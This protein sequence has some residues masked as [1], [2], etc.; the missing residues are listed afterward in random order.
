MLIALNRIEKEFQS[1]R[2]GAK[3]SV[4]NGINLTVEKGEL[5]AIRG[6]SGA[7]KSTLLHILGCLDRPTKGTYFLNGEDITNLPLNKLAW[8]RNQKIGF[9]LQH[10]SLVEEDTVLEN[11]GIPLL[12]GRVRMSL[13]D[14]MAMEQLHQLGIDHLANQR[15]GTLSGGEKQRVAIA[16]AL[17]NQPDIILADEP[18]GALDVKNSTMVMDILLQLH[19]Q[20]KTVIIVTHEAYVADLC[21]RV[22][23]ISDGQLYENR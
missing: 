22:I 8:I 19:N 6:S 11:V 2:K 13:I 15:A 5:L 12:L 16:R 3:T 10:F 23:T 18:T 1:N 9:V 14:A 17:I 4:L 7:G 21:E 20:G